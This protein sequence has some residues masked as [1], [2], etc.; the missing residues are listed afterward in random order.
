MRYLTETETANGFAN[1][2]DW[3]LVRR[4]KALPFG[5]RWSEVD[6]APLVRKLSS[7]LEFGKNA[8]DIKWGESGRGAWEPVYKDL[9][10]DRP[11][12]FGAVT[13]RGEAQA[14]R[15]ALLYA[16]MDKSRTIEGEHVEAALALWDYAEASARHIF[17]DATGDPVADQI[18][19]ALE[20]AGAAGM[21]RTEIRDLFKRHKNSERIDQALALLLKA[22]RVR[23]EQRDTGGRPVEVWFSK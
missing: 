13:A 9:S 19:E 16:V 21:S 10:D 12:L 6:T 14:L 22:G 11:G 2:F 1:R 20:A 23:R 3:L 4:S 5:G 7:A 17:G 15:L 18:G 8:G